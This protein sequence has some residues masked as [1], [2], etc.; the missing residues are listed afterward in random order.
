MVRFALAL[1]LFCGLAR[2]ES[3]I[4]CREAKDKDPFQ[5]SIHDLLIPGNAKL[6]AG[7]YDRDRGEFSAAAVVDTKVEYHEVLGDP[8]PHQYTHTATVQ[9]QTLTVE[10]RLESAKATGKA[11]LSWSPSAEMNCW[12]GDP[13]DPRNP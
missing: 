13:N 7:L 3:F 12:Y 5:F 4:T 11:V 1:T 10:I 2:A 9:N 8:F 6:Y